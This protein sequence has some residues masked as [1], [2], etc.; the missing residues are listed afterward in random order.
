MLYYFY[1]SFYNHVLFAFLYLLLVI[2]YLLTM[3]KRHN[4]FLQ[5]NQNHLFAIV[6]IIEKKGRKGCSLII[7]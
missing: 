3:L 5:N 4:N 2:Q 7:I 6:Y 1:N